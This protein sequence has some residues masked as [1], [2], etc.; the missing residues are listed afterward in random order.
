MNEAIFVLTYSAAFPIIF[1]L[2]SSVIV[3]QLKSLST[4]RERDTLMAMHVTVLDKKEKKKQE[5]KP[6]YLKWVV[7]MYRRNTNGRAILCN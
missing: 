4:E 5:G 1:I 6:P 3:N 7:E 2:F